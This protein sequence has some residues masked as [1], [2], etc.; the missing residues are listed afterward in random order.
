[1]TGVI[2]VPAARPSLQSA[3]AVECHAPF[4]HP[5]SGTTRPGAMCCGSSRPSPSPSIAR[6]SVPAQ[7]SEETWRTRRSS[8]DGKCAAPRDV[9][10]GEGLLSGPERRVDHLD[11]GSA[12]PLSHR[13]HRPAGRRPTACS[14]SQ[15]RSHSQSTIIPTTRGS[16]SSGA[17]RSATRY[18]RVTSPSRRACGSC[19]AARRGGASGRNRRC[20]GRCCRRRPHRDRSRAR[21]RADEVRGQ[22]SRAGVAIPLQRRGDHDRGHCDVLTIAVPFAQPRRDEAPR[23][24]TSHALPTSPRFGRTRSRS[25]SSCRRR[26]S[27]PLTRSP[28]PPPPR[29]GPGSRARSDRAHAS[30]A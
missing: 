23:A 20:V 27:G 15:R 10:L 12:I 7:S 5:H 26:C 6:G 18:G 13:K 21:R 19:R 14:R 3:A 1:M 9:S 22:P 28:P 16:G 11:F 29:T 25:R 8:L 30:R 24:R 4:A 17:A 2:T